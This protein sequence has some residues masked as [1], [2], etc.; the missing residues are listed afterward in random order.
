MHV[1]LMIKLKKHVLRVI[2]NAFDLK[3]NYFPPPPPQN[4]LTDVFSTALKHVV[5]YSH[6]A[7]S[8]WVHNLLFRLSHHMCAS[9]AGLAAAPGIWMGVCWQ[10]TPAGAAHM[11]WAG[12]RH[13]DIGY[14][15]QDKEWGPQ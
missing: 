12:P 3:G 4:N 2:E 6:K 15:V 13:P 1:S 11:S 7:N 10:A 5:N 9:V 14:G 8:V